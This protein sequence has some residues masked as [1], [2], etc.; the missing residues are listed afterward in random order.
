M[1]SPRF[2]GQML[3]LCLSGMIAFA[4]SAQ[5]QSD[6]PGSDL[7]AFADSIAVRHLEAGRYAAAGSLPIVSEVRA[8]IELQDDTASRSNRIALVRRALTERYG[9]RASE[10]DSEAAYVWAYI[11]GEWRWICLNIV[12]FQVDFGA[13][14]HVLVRAEDRAMGP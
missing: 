1:N 9:A 7:A 6:A 5:V 13:W 10:T 14:G 8:V 11:D 2:G 12:E 4:P 3:A